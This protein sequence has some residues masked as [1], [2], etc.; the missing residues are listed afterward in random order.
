MSFDISWI[1]YNWS[2]E[3]AHA[4]YD[5]DRDDMVHSV[6]LA[7]PY[8]TSHISC[9]VVASLLHTPSGWAA[10]MSFDISWIK[11][12]W[13][14]EAAHARYDDD[15]DDMVQSVLLASPYWTSHISC[16]VVASPL[17]Q[18]HFQIYI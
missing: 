11:Y 6:L 13:S 12:T 10:L 7:S 2:L 15:R 16:D 1:K 14:L 3:A 9:D 17:H 4:R 5:D 18:F 8:W